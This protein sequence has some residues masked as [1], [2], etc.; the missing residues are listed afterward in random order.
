MVKYYTTDSFGMR[1][2]LKKVK[3][4]TKKAPKTRKALARLVSGVINRKLETKLATYKVENNIAH[5]SGIGP[6]DCYRI[7]PALPNG[8][9]MYQRLGDTVQPMRLVV[10]GYVAVDRNFSQDNRPIQVRVLALGM[11]Q[12]KRWSTVQTAFAANYAHLLRYNDEGGTTV[13]QYTG[14]SQ[15]NLYPINNREFRVYAQRLI[16]IMP[17]QLSQGGAADPG[18]VES[19][20]RVVKHFRFTI[21]M[22]KTL[23]FEDE[24]GD[25]TPTNFAPFLSVGYQYLD[26]GSPDI[27][28]TRIVVNAVSHLT[29][30]DA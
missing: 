24:S 27:I 1:R 17:Q 25:N 15:D 11:V 13:G 28:N 22:P 5:N 23:K 3:K 18:S 12:A 7:C 21:P 8:D 2:T 9:E 14:S 26:G 20:G 30:K 29:Y 6:S 4:P 10:N 16:T 19:G